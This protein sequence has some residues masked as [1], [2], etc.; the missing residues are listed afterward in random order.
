MPSL[1]PVGLFGPPYGPAPVARLLRLSLISSST[2]Q[3]NAKLDKQAEKA[4]IA[5]QIEETK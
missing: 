4:K 2:A 5:E 1:P 3:Y